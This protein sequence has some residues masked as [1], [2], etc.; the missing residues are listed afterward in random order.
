MEEDSINRIINGGWSLISSN[1]KQVV[2]ESVNIDALDND[3]SVFNKSNFR[4]KRFF[5][6]YARNPFSGKMIMAIDFVD[7]KLS[8]AED[9][10]LKG[11]FFK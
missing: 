1:S 5:F 7:K 3:K 9:N 4:G 11:D 10:S 8:I 6:Y 2:F